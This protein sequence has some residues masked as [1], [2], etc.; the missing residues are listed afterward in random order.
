[1]ESYDGKM[2]FVEPMVSLDLLLTRPTITKAVPTPAKFAKS[3][4][5]PM[6]YSIKQVGEDVTISLDK[7]MLIQ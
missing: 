4:Y 6:K 3:G 1:M 7:L 2:A 5:F